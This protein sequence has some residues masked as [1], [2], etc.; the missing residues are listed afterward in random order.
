VLCIICYIS[1]VT[2]Y[3]AGTI[4]T[5]VE[6]NPRASARGTE[7]GALQHRRCICFGQTHPTW[8]VCENINCFSLTIVSSQHLPYCRLTL[9]D[10]VVDHGSYAQRHTSTSTSSST[11]SSHAANNAMKERD[12]Q[13]DEM[14]HN[15]M[16]SHQHILGTI[17]VRD[18][19]VQFV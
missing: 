1:V 9:S 11:H 16:Y 7:V 2:H 19:Y 17:H 12:R 5:R 3:S 4:Y 10:G 15:L 6:E 14:M 18:S 8:K 13:R